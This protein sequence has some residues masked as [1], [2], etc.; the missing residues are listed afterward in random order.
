[1]GI[2]MGGTDFPRSNHTQ[3]LMIPEINQTVGK[4]NFVSVSVRCQ[5]LNGNSNPSNFVF[6]M[7]VQKGPDPTAP[8]IYE[9]SIVNGA[10]VPFGV[11][12]AN[13]N[14]YVNKPANC[15]WSFADRDY[16]K[17]ENNMTCATEG[18][19]MN[20]RLS[21]T[22]SANL[23]GIKTAEK[24][25][26]YVKCQ[27]LSPQNNTNKDYYLKPEGYTLQGSRA[28]VITEA[29]PNATTIYDSTSPAS[30]TFN[31]KTLGGTQD[32]KAM[33]FYREVGSTGLY[34]QFDNSDYSSNIHSTIVPLK[35]GEHS[36]SIKCND[37]GGN[38]DTQVINFNVSIDN[39]EPLIARA[40]YE[41]NQL[42]IMTNEKAE[43]RYFTS[44]TIQCN[45]EFEDGDPITSYDQINHLAKWNTDEDLYIKCQDVYGNQP[46]K[47]N[48]CSIIL[49]AQNRNN[50]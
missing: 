8:I 36:Y 37:R 44:S 31:T 38:S 13:V 47:P 10:K 21:Y 34:T 4:D 16:D 2:F 35:N 20:L 28:L 17:M 27:D 25:S 12:N 40:Y 5:D 41:D 42:K 7:C 3:T 29:S 46:A 1:M 48:E 14:F 23:T 32:G 43:C 19:Q 24:T 9:T 18:S 33:C 22:C 26:Y 39:K 30:V 11:T 6:D 50:L 45:Y 15:R 49:R